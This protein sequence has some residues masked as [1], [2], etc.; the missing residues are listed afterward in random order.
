MR[1]DEL[2]RRTREQ[3]PAKRWQHTLGVVETAVR[4]AAKYGADPQKAELAA[5]LHDYCKYWPID[6]QIEIL[7]SNPDMPQDLLDYDPQLLHSHVG[8]WVAREELG[9]DDEEVLDAIRWHTSGRV[10]MTT[11][12]KVICLAD[13][14]EPGRDFPGVAE[15]RR[16][17]ASSLER[18]LVAGFDSTIQFLI[19]R[20]KKIY[21]LTVMSRNGLIA[22]TEGFNGSIG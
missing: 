21:P 16:L 8:A 1:L 22:E 18:A 12:D 10:G 14:I 13:Y 9:V 17:A 19:Q 4:L 5:V 3:M 11:L 15:I 7:R 2:K 6:R 20:G